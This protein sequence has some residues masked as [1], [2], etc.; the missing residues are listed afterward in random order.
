MLDEGRYGS[1]SE[2]A[3]AERIERGYVGKMLQ[4]TLLAPHMVEAIVDGR[5]SADV[6]LPALMARVP[7]IWAD[8][9]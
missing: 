2:L 3:A 9:W 7:D 4:L 8:R 1:I 5:Q 6:T